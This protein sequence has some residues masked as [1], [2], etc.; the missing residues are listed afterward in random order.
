MSRNQKNT[1]SA[2]FKIRN[3]GPTADHLL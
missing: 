3:F 2:F 1:A